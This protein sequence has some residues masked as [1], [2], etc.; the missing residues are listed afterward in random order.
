[1]QSTCDTKSL[2]P[3]KLGFRVGAKSVERI[4]MVLAGLLPKVVKLRPSKAFQG[5]YEGINECGTNPQAAGNPVP[6]T[7]CANHI[8]TGS[9]VAHIVP[10]PVQMF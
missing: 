4:S 3:K 10:P 2:L 9:M 7:A 1:M 6:E 8:T 5:A